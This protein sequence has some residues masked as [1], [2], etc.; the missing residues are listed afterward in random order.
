MS[1]ENESNR[2]ER[3]KNF[4]NRSFG[5]GIRKKAHKYYSITLKSRE[6]YREMLKSRASDANVLEY[7]CG[8]GSHSFMIAEHGGNVTGIDISDVAIDLAE[9][10][11]KKKGLHDRI[12]FSVMD[13]EKLKF[14]NSSFDLICGTGIL[15][16]LDLGRSFAEISR[17]LT[18]DGVA[19]FIEP[20]GHNPLINF[21]RKLTPN[22]R[23]ED[24]HPLL[25]KDIKLAEMHFGKV[26]IK[27]FHFFSLAAVPF[28]NTP[29]FK[30]FLS[31]LDLIDLVFFA[32]L[33]FFRKYSWT[34]VMKLS[35]PN[36]KNSIK[37]P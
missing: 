13:A 15:H 16:H 2:L 25:I 17:V 12:S 1:Q 20:L 6:Y 7:G 30:L 4:H 23:T 9:E 29:I 11:A 36:K 35:A 34:I 21:Y 8:P 3:E 5:E 32:A 33:P 27:Y 31:F 24:E 37:N 22:L 26:E 19:V 28:R 18:D 14:D 10:E